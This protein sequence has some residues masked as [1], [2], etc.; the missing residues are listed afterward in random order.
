MRGVSAQKKDSLVY[1]GI[2][3]VPYSK[4]PVDT[5]LFNLNEDLGK[6]LMPIDSIL[7]YAVNFSPALKFEDNQIKKAKGN[8]QYTR[9]LFLNGVTGF[10][11]YTYGN[12]TNLNSVNSDGSVLNNSLGLGYRVGAN[13][14]FPLTEVFGRPGRMRSLKAELEMT[15]YKRMDAEIEIR[16][17]VIADYYNLIAAQKIVNV[18]VQDAESARLTV[19]I[20]NVEMRRGKIHPSDLSRLKNVL[21]I[22]ESNL[23]LSKRDFMV[24]FYQLETMMGT[25]LHNLKRAPVNKK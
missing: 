9:Y 16:R 8:L 21:A 18:R 15:K 1:D 23:E 13:I 3:M 19:E 22:A 24:Y 11:N 12:Q 20:A 14:T 2:S 6:Q 17:K 25:R 5:I 4:I 10:Y 7:N